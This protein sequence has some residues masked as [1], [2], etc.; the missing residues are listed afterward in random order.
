MWEKD[1]SAVRTNQIE[2]VLV[3]ILIT[4]SIPGPRW[5]YSVRVRDVWR[6]FVDRLFCT[7][8]STKRLPQSQHHGF[9]RLEDF[10]SHQ[11][12]QDYENCDHCEQDEGCEDRE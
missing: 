4:S 7:R 12:R 9:H 11:E 10:P 3:V 1:N 5:A 6:V 2:E 8:A